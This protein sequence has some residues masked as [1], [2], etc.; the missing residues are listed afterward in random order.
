MTSPPIPSPDP[1]GSAS[2]P[3]SPPLPDRPLRRGARRDRRRRSRLGVLVALPMAMSIVGVSAIV[4]QSSSAAFSATTSNAGNS[5]ATGTVAVSD[6]DSAAAMFTVPSM[7]PGDTG[8]KCIKLTYT[9]TQNALVKLY[10]TAA[11]GATLRPYIDVVIT[12]GTG[13]T[14]ASCT[15]FSSTSTI[16]TGTL[17]A[18][19][20]GKTDYTSGVGS[21][22]Q[23]NTGATTRTYKI[24]WTFNAAAPNTTQGQSSTVTFQWEARGV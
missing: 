14:F 19:V 24:D 17:D 4:W 12:E 9:G 15:G 1:R 18:F 23:M 13:G 21:A 11:T 8:S 7:L 16:F 20:T 3:S 22:T 10:Q 5:W 6:D 2:L